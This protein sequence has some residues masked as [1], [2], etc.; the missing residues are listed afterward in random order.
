MPLL[1]ALAADLALRKD[2]ILKAPAPG[3]AEVEVVDLGVRVTVRPTSRQ[4]WMSPLLLAASILWTMIALS[5]LGLVA[6][7]GREHL[8]AIGTVVGLF[9]AVGMIVFIQGLRIFNRTIVLLGT[10]KTLKVLGRDF[11]GRAEKEW[12][13]T[14]IWG[15]E[16]ANGELQLRL[17][18]GKRPTILA[19][20]DVPTLE[21]IAGILRRARARKPVEIVSTSQARGTCQVCATEMEERIVWCRRCRTP[22]H[23]E[24]WI[25]TGMCSTFGCREIGYVEC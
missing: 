23:R 15:F 19:G 21:W 20:R 18:N 7:R 25:Y 1:E 11:L 12:A 3:P 17:A 6:E 24:C 22:H 16:V 5:F 9:W 14:E 4:R 13:R 8:P 10:E 2:E